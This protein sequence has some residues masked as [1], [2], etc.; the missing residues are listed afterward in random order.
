FYMDADLEEEALFSLLRNEA[1]N[2]VYCL[3][4]RADGKF[5][6][7]IMS[8]RELF[9]ERNKKH[10]YEVFGAARGRNCAYALFAEYIAEG[11]G[12]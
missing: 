8:A 6:C 2:G 12:L 5:F 1:P 3:C 9:T 4:R 10:D 7:E 11:G